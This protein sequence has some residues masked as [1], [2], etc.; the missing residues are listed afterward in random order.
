[1]VRLLKEGSG[2]LAADYRA[3]ITDNPQSPF[4]KGASTNNSGE[5]VFG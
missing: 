4:K 3:K 5:G 2:A 1:M